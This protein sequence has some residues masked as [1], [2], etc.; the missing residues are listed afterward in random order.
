MRYYAY[1]PGCSSSEGGAKAYG[2]S[3]QA[4][5]KA[6][7]IELLELDD[8]NCCGSTPYSSFEELASFCLSAR[9]LA[10][11]E[12]TGLD[13]VTPCSSCY[14]ILNRANSYLKQYPDLKAKVDESLA[15]GG[16]EYKGTVRVRHLLDIFVNDIGYDTIS[17]TVKKSLEGL[18]VAPYY[19]CQLVR[20][21]FGFDH[22]EMPESI[23]KLIVSLGGE[24]INFPKK[25]RCCGGSL[26]ISEEDLSLSLI[27][28]VLKSALDNGAECIITP[29]PLCQ[30]NLDAYQ[31]SADKRF[32]TSFNLPVLFFTQLMG[33][34]FGLVERDLGLKSCIVPAETV[35][36]KY[37]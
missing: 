7:G 20:P 19:G 29:C 17:A 30:T 1:F 10:L 36:G 27:G 3:A 13:L 23:D 16:L 31:K 12:K 22:P 33:V 25:A 8:W 6:L 28:K 5:S 37:L 14:V 4:V 21:S 26:I 34:A 18:K 9:N 15:A 2:V 32:M 24:T 11:A 35:L